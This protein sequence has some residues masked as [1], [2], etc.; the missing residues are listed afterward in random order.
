MLAIYWF[1]QF[2]AIT[3]APLKATGLVAKIFQEN[4]DS[5]INGRSALAFILWTG[6]SG[7]FVA[8]FIVYVFKFIYNIAIGLVQEAIPK[9]LHHFITPVVFLIA[10]WPCFRYQR[11]IKTVYN[12]L[13][14]EG[15]DIVR[16]AKG[17]DIKLEI[18]NKQSASEEFNNEHNKKSFND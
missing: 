13:C 6:T 3:P 8:G 11:E 4:D 17:F 18:K 2:Y 14:R 15:S 5:G 12:T 16:L 10:M 7:I 1:Y 9:K